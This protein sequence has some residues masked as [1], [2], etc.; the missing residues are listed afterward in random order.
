MA[1]VA[2]CL[3]EVLYL[4][5]RSQ[6][7]R[8]PRHELSSLTQTLGSCFRIP[9]EAWMSVCF[10]SVFVLSCVCRPCDGLIPCLRSRTDYVKNQ[11]TEK[12]VKALQRAV[13]P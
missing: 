9:L 4:S 7:P 13:Q 6:W 1:P 5:S 2:D 12:A 3:K 10:Y 11:E 8:S